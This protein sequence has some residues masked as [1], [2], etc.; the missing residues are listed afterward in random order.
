MFKVVKKKLFIRNIAEIAGGAG[1][2]QLL[3]VL[4]SPILTRL[5][6]PED[7]GLFAIFMAVVASFFM[8][9]SGKYETAM[10]LPKSNNQ[11]KDLLGIAIY[12]LFIFFSILML[13]FLAIKQ[14]I[15]VFLD[16]TE[17]GN[18]ILLVP[19]MIFAVSFSEIFSFYANRYKDFKYIGNSKLI[20]H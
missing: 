1:M 2:A 17:M 20:R 3:M 5:Y 7:F 19:V 18:W 4:A 10:I 12:F 15:I 8:G 14:E 11:G 6:S 16:V 13:V 9:A